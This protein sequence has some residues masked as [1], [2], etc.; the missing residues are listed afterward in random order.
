[1]NRLMVGKRGEDL[2]ATVA[3][4]QGYR[5]VHRNYRCPL[6]EIDLILERNST[7]V[8]I[9][10]KTRSSNRYGEPWEAVTPTK[11]ERIR[12]VAT[13]Y[14]REQ[15]LNPAAF[16]FDVFTVLLGCQ[17]WQYRWFQEAF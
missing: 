11:Q 10:V 2:A 5:V 8:F 9:E 16:R 6:G 4:A 15:E 7:L 12:R 14:L 3:Q 13:W 17:P 1:M